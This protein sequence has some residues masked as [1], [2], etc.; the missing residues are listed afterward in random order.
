MEINGS[1]NY[2][3]MNKINIKINII[4]S[5]LYVLDVGLLEEKTLCYEVRF[6]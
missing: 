4:N 1:S 6:Y 5:D 2:F 3:K